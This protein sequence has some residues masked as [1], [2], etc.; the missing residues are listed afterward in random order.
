VGAVAGATSGFGDRVNAAFTTTLSPVNAVHPI[1][2]FF[3]CLILAGLVWLMVTIRSGGAVRLPA[4]L[5]VATAA[6]LA[7]RVIRFGPTFVPGMVPTA[8]LVVAGV[9][10]GTR[11]RQ[12]RILAGIALGALPLIFL[13]QYPAGAVPQWGGRYM[14]LTGF[15]LVVVAC[16]ELPRVHLGAFR[17][18]LL[19]G[20]L[21]TA[22][23][24]WFNAVRTTSLVEDFAVIEAVAD[25]D[26][27]VW[28]D[29]VKAREAGPVIVDHRWLS[30]VGD[31]QRSTVLSILEAETVDRFVYVDQIGAD[32]V[33][34]EGFG[35][36]SEI[37]EWELSPILQLRLTIYER[38]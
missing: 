22:S 30:T 17:G 27:V 34:F 14:L 10:L 25:G 33:D 1:A 21:V 16:A 35:A 7:L 3:G 20:V 18:L 32:V 28:Y 8:P 26:V 24:V 38:E 13:T 19:T 6:V 15:L 23:G 31:A 11:T 37:G 5:L 36:V 4:T 29:N 2:T 9:F 12:H